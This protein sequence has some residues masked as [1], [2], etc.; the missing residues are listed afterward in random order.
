MAIFIAQEPTQMNTAYT[1][2][3]YTVAASDINKPQ[4][5]F[6]CDVLDYNNNLISRL[7]Q[8]ANNASYA[9]FN[10]AVPV[11][12]HLDEDQTFYMNN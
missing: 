10:V 2:L 8:P 3:M 4:Y 6:V 12:A 11:R 9:V 1:K 5:K 7:K